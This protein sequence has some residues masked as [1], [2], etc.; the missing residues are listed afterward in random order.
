[1]RKFKRWLG[2]MAMAFNQLFN[3]MTGG[4]PD[5]ATSARAGYAREHGSKV[6]AGAC[7][8]LDWLDPR[9]GDSPKGDHCDIAIR[10]HEKVKNG[11]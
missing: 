7:H 11:R 8:L 10:N 9:D 6:G 2:A 1:M 3:T 4:D 5:M